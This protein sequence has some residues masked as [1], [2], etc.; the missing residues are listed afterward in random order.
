MFHKI[1][2]HFIKF[3]KRIIKGKDY[4]ESSNTFLDYLRSKGIKI[5]Q[6]TYIQNTYNIQIDITR[7]ELLEIGAN[8]FLHN[9][10]KILTHDY[11]SW[12]FIHKYHEFFPSHAAVRIGNNV[13][14]GENVTILKGVSIGDN[15]IIGIG[16][17]VTKS[18][19]ANS[20]AV[21]IPA[22]VI[23]SLDD[24]YQRRSKEYTK[25]AIEYAKAIIQSG[26]EPVIEDFY[27]DYP[28]FVDQSNYLKYNYPYHRVFTSNYDFEKWLAQHKATFN[29]FD[30]FIEYVKQEN[31]NSISNST[32]I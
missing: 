15:V 8:V 19:P 31:A 6:G 13:W 21:G 7:P 5:G 30:E 28:A 25:E 26:R 22:K 23:C 2:L 18:I 9:G 10:C 27:D 17:V 11:A 29:G 4:R 16:S 3:L 24:Y 32:H 1:L 20:V 14:L 12:C